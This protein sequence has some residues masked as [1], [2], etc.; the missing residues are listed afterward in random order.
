[1]RLSLC[2]L[3]LC[4][5]LTSYAQEPLPEQSKPASHQSKKPTIQRLDSSRDWLGT[6]IN[7]TSRNLDHYF[8]E[9]FFADEVINGELSHN[10][11]AKLFLRSGV[12]EREGLE[13]GIGLDVRLRLPNTEEHFDLV[14][15]SNDESGDRVSETPANTN[16]NEDDT[17]FTGLQ[18]LPKAVK[19]WRPRL[20]L[21]A[22]WSS[23]PELFLEGRLRRRFG[24]ENHSVQTT[25]SA[26]HYTRRKTIL[27]AQVNYFKSL[28]DNWGFRF[29]NRV[30]YFN[31]GGYYTFDHIPALQQRIDANNA[32]V[33]RLAASG[34]D[35]QHPF[36]DRYTASIRW[37]HR[38]YQS[39]LFIELEPSH[40]YFVAPNINGDPESEAALFVRLEMLI[41]ND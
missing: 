6:R 20:Q 12:R 26:A 30:R 19:K 33:Y 39:W 27:T 35:Q 13:G 29:A 9:R 21:G 22:R 18:Y 10:S 15:S 23:S 8:M 32:F 17:L 38:L 16:P 3:M 2:L 1:M 31:S 36:I 24:H 14:I 40:T 11:K 41:N 34:D 37:R 7:N 5:S 28:S 4:S 25:F